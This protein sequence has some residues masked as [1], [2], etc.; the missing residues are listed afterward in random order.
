[1]QSTTDLSIKGAALC[2]HITSEFVVVAATGGSLSF[3]NLNGSGIPRHVLKYENP[4]PISRV[5]CQRDGY[6]AT[7]RQDGTLALWQPFASSLRPLLGVLNVPASGGSTAAA[8]F[9][10]PSTIV[11]DMDFSASNARIIAGGS[12]S[13]AVHIYDTR[14]SFTLH[15]ATR[16]HDDGTELFLHKEAPGGVQHRPISTPGFGENHSQ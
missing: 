15:R 16:N 6:L 14:A 11:T 12:L 10:E 3:F 9:N 1:M 7:L 4:V 13:G 8:S 5:K 2:G